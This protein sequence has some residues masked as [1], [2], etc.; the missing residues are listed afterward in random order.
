[1]NP[2]IENVNNNNPGK[3]IVKFSGP[4]VTGEYSVKMVSVLSKEKSIF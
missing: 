1:M 2:I 3:I 4:F